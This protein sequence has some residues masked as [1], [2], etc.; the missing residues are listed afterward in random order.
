[1]ESTLEEILAHHGIKGMR[2]GRHKPKAPGGGSSPAP[3]TAAPKREAPKTKPLTFRELSQ[4][5]FSGASEPH[6]PREAAPG[7][8]REEQLV[9]RVVN[10]GY[11][12]TVG[13]A[14]ALHVLNIPRHTASADQNVNDL[15]SRVLN[16]SLNRVEEEA[17]R[18]Y[19][20]NLPLG[21]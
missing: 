12:R 6:R 17:G 4:P 5:K 8:S 9:S 13:P 2:W 15:L 3:K 11:N 1:M 10:Q 16:Q 7:A 21:R 20:Q 19:M 14:M 18:T